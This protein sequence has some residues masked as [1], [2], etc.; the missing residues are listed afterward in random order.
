MKRKQKHL[1]ERWKRVLVEKRLARRDAEIVAEQNYAQSSERTPEELRELYE[2]GSMTSKIGVAQNPNLPP[3]MIEAIAQSP[4]KVLRCCIASHPQAPLP[5]L[6]EMAQDKE[7]LV[8]A[9]AM[10][11]LYRKTAG[12]EGG[13]LRAKRLPDTRDGMVHTVWWV[14]KP[15]EE[16]SE[17]TIEDCLVQKGRRRGKR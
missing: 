4:K 1:S 13:K 12:K 8:S 14:E 10:S 16:L 11:T 2:N 9:I 3:D 5:L 17:E 6:R 7:E 15:G